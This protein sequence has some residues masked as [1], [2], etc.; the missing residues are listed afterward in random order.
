MSRVLERECIER[1]ALLGYEIDKPSKIQI[2][3]SNGMTYIE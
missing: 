3:T 2:K 1:L